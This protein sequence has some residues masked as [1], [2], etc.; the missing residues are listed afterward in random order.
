MVVGWKHKHPEPAGETCRC[1]WVQACS[2]H[3]ESGGDGHHGQEGPGG[4]SRESDGPSRR[5][6]IQQTCGL[7]GYRQPSHRFTSCLQKG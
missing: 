3:N 6:R 7:V 5:E 1:K 4:A 2:G